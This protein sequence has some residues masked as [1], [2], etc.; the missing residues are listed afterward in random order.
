MFK[1]HLDLDAPSQ[2]P[3]V[4]DAVESGLG[5]GGLMAL[6]LKAS[7]A[8]EHMLCVDL[9]TTAPTC[10]QTYLTPNQPAAPTM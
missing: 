3:F 7:P 9:P 8:S 6:G 4:G 2:L 5:A 10:C 1:V